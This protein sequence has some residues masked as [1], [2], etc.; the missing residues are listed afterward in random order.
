MATTAGKRP[1]RPGQ[2]AGRGTT[3]AKADGKR[4]SPAGPEGAVG[5]PASK[6]SLRNQGR[7]P[8]LDTPKS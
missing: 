4:S 5:V 7:K 3:G 2:T 8:M 1:A 6:R